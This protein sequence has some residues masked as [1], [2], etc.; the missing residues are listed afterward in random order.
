MP[1]LPSAKKALRRDQRRTAVNRRIRARVKGAV[2]GV[3][4]EP[5]ADT[6][7]RAYSMLD[8]AA[9]RRIIHPHKAARIKSRLTMVVQT[10]QK[11]AAKRRT[12]A[13]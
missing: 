10:K 6:L 3:I 7:R 4:Q 9:K 12:R 1:L 5:S 13:A 2:D 11:T 8:R